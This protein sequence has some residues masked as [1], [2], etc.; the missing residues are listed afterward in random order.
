MNS[1]LVSVV[2][3]VRDAGVYLSESVSS[4]LSQTVTDMELLLVD[5]H[6]TDGAVAALDCTDHRLKILPSRGK[7][8][9][10]AFNTGLAAA[11]GAFVA[12]MDGDDIALPER[13]SLQL[14]YL[15]RN[16]DVG[17]AGGCVDI[18]A[19]DGVQGG[20]RR[21]QSWLNSVRSTDDIRNAMFIESPIP[22]PTALF[23]HDVITVLGGYRDVDWPEDYDLYLRADTAGIQMGKPEPVI[24]RWRDH[25]GRLTRNDQ[26]YTLH[27]FRR[28]RTHFLVA[29]RLQG[30]DVVIWGAGPTGKNMHDLLVQEGA[31]VTAFIDVHPRRIGGRKRDLPVWPVE[32]AGDVGDALILVAVGAA[33]ARAEIR[34]F[35]RGCGRREGEHYLFVA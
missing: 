27:A 5:D 30:R 9:V 32:R 34:E 18:F 2:L 25:D 15:H 28:V 10:A 7:G 4:I 24:L 6:S 35:M 13:L 12:R 3:P 11:R 33:G 19:V 1:V 26:R 16:P 20:N 21:Y 23:R 31:H 8:V 22:N 14:D 29:N 17:I